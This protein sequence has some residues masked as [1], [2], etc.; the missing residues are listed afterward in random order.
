MARKH[1]SPPGSATGL[2]AERSTGTVK[3]FEDKKGYGFITV[4]DGG[5]DCFVHHSAI[6]AEGFRTLSEGDRVE[7]AIEQ[8]AKGPQAI[9]VVK[10]A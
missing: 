6:S 8:A 7:F 5:K 9:N 3:W 1:G 10:I 2:D 4:D